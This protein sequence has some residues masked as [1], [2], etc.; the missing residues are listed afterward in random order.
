MVAQITVPKSIKRTLNYNEKKVQQGKAELIH[1]QN[2]LKLPGEMNF[3]DKLNRFERQMELNERAQTKVIHISLNFPPEEKEKMTQEFLVTLADEYMERIGFGNQPYLVYEHHDSGHPHVHIVSTLIKD[4]GSR[5]NTHHLG[6][7]VSD[8]ARKEMEVK[9]GL[10]SSNKKQWEQKQE[11]DLA[12]TPQKIQA[13]KSAA[14]RSITNVLDHVVSRYKYTSLNELNAVLKLYNVKADRGVE[15][16]RIHSNRGLTY[17]VIDKDGKAL[18]KPIKASAFHSKPTLDYI[19]KKCKENEQ[20]R[21]PDKK[22]IKAAIEWA[23]RSGPRSLSELAKL[24]RKDRIDIVVRRNEQGRVF[25]MTYIDHEKKAVFNGSDI[26]KEYAAKRILERLGREPQQQPE[27]EQQKQQAAV[28]QKGH[29]QDKQGTATK[30]KAGTLAKQQETRKEPNKTKAPEKE[31]A[32]EELGKG[33]AKIIE[34]VVDPDSG[35][36]WAINKEMLTEKQR[37]K[38]K[39]FNKQWEL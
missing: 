6:K 37:K 28:R 21:L 30:E 13:G 12:V 1:A 29:S 31:P 36:S 17:V 2:F 18:T 9:Y 8:P 32:R 39:G 25:G 27:K 23:M 10:I 3:H 11:K 26:G 34:Q 22:H 15:E 4:D 5:I 24:L 35:E 38:K 14:M 7:E 19:E 20:K 33:V 16:G